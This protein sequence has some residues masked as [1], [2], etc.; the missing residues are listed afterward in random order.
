[1]NLFVGSTVTLDNVAGTSVQLVQTTDY[2]WNG[3]VALTVNPAAP[4]EVRAQDP[5]A[6]PPD[7]RALHQHPGGRRA[8]SRS[9][10]TASRSSRR[11]SSGYAVLDRTWKAGDKVEL[12]VP[13]QV[14]R[15]KASDQI[16]ATRGRVALR[17]GPLIYNLESVDQNLDSVLEPD[18]AAGHR[19]ARRPAGRRD[20]DQGRVRRRQAAAR[21]PQLRPAQPRRPVHRLDERPIKI[22]RPELTLS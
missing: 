3:K 4:E 2:P 12:E 9:P 21:H 17:Y 15:V 19:M 14:Q 8:C 7:Q 10:S 22:R 11:S 6:E 5:R 18:R 1:M 20:G 13:L 16:A